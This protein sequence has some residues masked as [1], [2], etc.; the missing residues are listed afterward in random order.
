MQDPIEAAEDIVEQA[1]R[2]MTAK[3]IMEDARMLLM[4]SAAGADE[5]EAVMLSHISARGKRYTSAAVASTMQI[6]RTYWSRFTGH[7]GEK[8][9]EFVVPH[10]NE[11]DVLP[12]MSHDVARLMLGSEEDIR[13]GLLKLQAFADEAEAVEYGMVCVHILQ[14]AGEFMTDLFEAAKV[15]VRGGSDQED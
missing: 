9:V 12:A 11:T 10:D 3:A 4:M 1:S 6:A 5:A 8:L 14:I 15:H 13:A 7:P 2:E